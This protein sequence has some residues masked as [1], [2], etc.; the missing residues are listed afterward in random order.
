MAEIS[1]R[2]KKLR[3]LADLIETRDVVQATGLDTL[4]GLDHIRFRD[5]LCI[6]PSDRICVMIRQFL[7][8]LYNNEITI[9]ERNLFW[10][11]GI[12]HSEPYRTGI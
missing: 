4:N 5:G 10:N 9:L 3:E 2:V 1:E 12:K 6:R 8:G 11:D 7:T